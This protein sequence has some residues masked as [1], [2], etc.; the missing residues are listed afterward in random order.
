[1]SDFDK[2]FDVLMLSEVGPWFDSSDIE[3]QLGLISTKAQQKKCGYV[4]NPADPGGLTKFGIAKNSNP[5]VDVANLTLKQAAEIYQMKYWKPCEKFGY[6]LN[7]MFFDMVVLSGPTA[8][9]KVIQRALGVIDDGIIGSNTMLAVSKWDSKKL[10]D[11]Y[12][13]FREIW[14]INLSISRPDLAVF[15]KGWLNRIAMLRK[16]LG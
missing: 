12:L 7:V 3:T 9:S 15:K 1:M 5:T 11:K 14:F 13:T 16:W 6:P 10:A 8:A 4:N 2:A